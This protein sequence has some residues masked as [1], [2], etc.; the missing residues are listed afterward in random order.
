MVR[1]APAR[2]F[3]KTLG[4]VRP[5]R[6]Y[7]AQGNVCAFSSSSS[8]ATYADTINNLRIGAHTKVLFQGFTGRQATFNAKE[9]IEYGTKVVGG[10]KPGFE[11]EHLGLPVFP[12][13][14]TAVDKLKPDASAIYVPGNGTVAAMEEAIEAEIPL[15]IAVAEHIPIH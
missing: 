10:V 15:I 9:C 8:C 4:S 12:S 3:Q 6:R 13:V 11:G 14:R 7:N 5:I 2:G 1:V